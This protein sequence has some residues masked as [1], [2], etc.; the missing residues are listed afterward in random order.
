MKIGYARV[1]TRSQG[2]SLDTQEATLR[3]HGCERVFRDTISGAK[4]SRPGFDEMLK[5]LR[6]GDEVFATRLDRLGRTAL[7]TLRTIDKLNSEGVHVIVLR[8]EIDTRT[9]EGKLMAGIMAHLAEF[10]RD[11][12]I[13]RTREGL[14]AAR[15]RGRM[16][17]RPASIT[18]KQRTQLVR[19]VD[20]HGESV[21]EAAKVLGIS[22]SHAYRIYGEESARQAAATDPAGPTTA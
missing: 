12:L 8:P 15:A 9:K 22:R 17:G 5:M 16:G 13:E 19:M 14:V 4:S 3:E 18:V 20:E 1:S 11:L 7:D 6:P 21:P 10:E 2:D